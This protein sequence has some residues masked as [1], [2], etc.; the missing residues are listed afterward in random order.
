MPRGAALRCNLLPIL[1]FYMWLGVG[2][3][4]TI[5]LAPFRK[6]VFS[7][8]GRTL[9]LVRP[10]A[11][12]LHRMDAL[13]EVP[14]LSITEVGGTMLDVALDD[15]GAWLAAL[16][17]YAEGDNPNSVLAFYDTTSGER[18]SGVSFGVVYQ[19]G[20]V[21]P[22]LE[23]LTSSPTGDRLALLHKDFLELWDVSDPQAPR[24]VETLDRLLPQVALPAL[25]ASQLAAI[26]SNPRNTSDILQ[27]DAADAA[28]RERLA[29]TTA[30]YTLLAFSDN[31]KLLV[32]VREEATV[33][34]YDIALREL[35]QV[36][37]RAGVDITALD[38][39][40]NLLAIGW[41][42]P[43]LGPGMRAGITVYDIDSGAERW[44]V[45]LSEAPDALYLSA[46]R[47]I[48]TSP[49]SG[50]ISIYVLP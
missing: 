41:R 8:D 36:I 17:F 39:A 34:I 7:A 43:G 14:F 32:A 26:E 5:T 28:N 12:A 22:A 44:S 46:Q 48:A 33:E 49:D 11:I 27:W 3:A 4:Q 20:A 15:A 23:S 6:S 13:Q 1:I 16:V 31:G 9:A 30:Y 42:T 37:S 18:L 50:L 21:F 38:V 19:A 2:A 35:V 29:R 45:P 24:K 10:G 25:S 47:L 40:A